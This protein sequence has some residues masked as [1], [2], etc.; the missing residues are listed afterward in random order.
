MSKLVDIT[1]K[2]YGYLLVL[3]RED[4]TSTGRASWLCKCDCG[5]KTIVS[6][7]NLRNGNTSSCGCRRTQGLRT[8]HGLSKKKDR[9][10]NI[11]LGMKQRCY[12]VNG[13][14]YKDYGGRGIRVCSRWKNSFENFYVDMKESHDKHLAIFGKD[15]TTLDRIDNNGNYEPSNCKWSTRSEQYFNSR[16]YKEKI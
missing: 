13:R 9:L 5:G 2:K 12:Y 1:G 4:N 8:T 11:W 14:S 7:K 16:S 15:N 10:Y 6:G 3:S